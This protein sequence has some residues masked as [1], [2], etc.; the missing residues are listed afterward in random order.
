MTATF[1]QEGPRLGNS[2]TSNW[3]LRTYL[4]RKLGPDLMAVIEPELVEL[5][6][7]AAGRLFEM[8][9]AD[10][11]N[12]PVSLDVLLRTDDERGLAALR[13]RIKRVVSSAG[14]G[15]FRRSADA[16]CAAVEHAARWRSAAHDRSSL[17]IGAR[18]IAMTLARALGLAL[19]VEHGGAMR[20]DTAAA[21]SREACRRL[22]RSGVDSILDE[23]SA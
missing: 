5:G 18:R 17:Q 4:E 12:E 16:A 13:R 19:L 21:A 23:E 14:D 3:L 2:Y 7:L 1:V 10:R 8:Q 11:C 9:R 6:E 20:D 15:E 22:R